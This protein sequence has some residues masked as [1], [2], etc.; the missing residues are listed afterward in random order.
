MVNTFLYR[1]GEG[2]EIIYEYL[3][4]YLIKLQNWPWE[5]MSKNNFKKLLKN[6]YN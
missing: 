2:K 6:Q 1:G 5:K 4:S 3:I